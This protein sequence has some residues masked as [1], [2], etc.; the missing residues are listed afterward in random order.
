MMWGEMSGDHQV[1][2][3]AS[4][5]DI[6]PISQKVLNYPGNTGNSASYA[7]SGYHIQ[8]INMNGS[9]KYAGS[10]ND[11]LMISQNVLNNPKNIIQSAS[12]PILKHVE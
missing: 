5:N 9:V 2:Y 7:V 4:W 6:L 11:V 3:A 10:N 8:D 12:F 1:K